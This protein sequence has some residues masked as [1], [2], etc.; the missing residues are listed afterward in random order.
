MSLAEGATYLGISERKLWNELN[1]GHVKAARIGR[2]IIFTRT[3]LDR[4]I[5]LL[6][7]AA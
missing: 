6:M 4:Y 5:A 2:R 3:E 1:A 7:A